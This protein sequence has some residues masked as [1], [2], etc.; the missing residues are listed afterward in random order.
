MWEEEALKRKEDIR[1]STVKFLA[2]SETYVLVFRNGC[3]TKKDD[4]IYT[5]K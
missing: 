3:I 5:R 4:D 2:K 1:N